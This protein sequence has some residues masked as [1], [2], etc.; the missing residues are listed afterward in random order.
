MSKGK[1]VV[2]S[3]SNKSSKNIILNPNSTDRKKSIWLFDKLDRDAKFAFNV[4]R[5]DFD[6]EK[7]LSKIIDY[8][9]MTWAEIKRQTHDGSKS[10][11]HFLDTDGMSDDARKRIEALKLEDST[12]QIFSFAL[13]NKIRIIGLRN[14]EFFHV[15][16]FDPLHEFY[17]SEKKHT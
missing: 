6:A 5:S 15:I 4:Y 8:S 13:E 3:G 11:N 2:R 9:N 14:D 17:L 16:W 10:K 12:D 1:K 7:I